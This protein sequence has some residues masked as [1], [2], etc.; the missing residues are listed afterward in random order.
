MATAL[1]SVLGGREEVNCP[2]CERPLVVSPKPGSG[3]R[4][5]G[6]S[7]KCQSM[8]WIPEDSIVFGPVG[9]ALTIWRHRW[10]PGQPRPNCVP[11]Y[12]NGG[13]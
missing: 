1:E 2:I 13:W 3:Y 11:K 8:Y 10:N 4:F 9:G 6:C 5:D 7:R 12:T